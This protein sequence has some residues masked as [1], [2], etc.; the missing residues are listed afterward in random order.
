MRAVTPREVRS[1]FSHGSEV[2]MR[3]VTLAPPV[4]RRIGRLYNV[5]NLP[6]LRSHILAVFQ[7]PR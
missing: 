6:F 7:K 2:M 1:L 4:G 3:K 5:F